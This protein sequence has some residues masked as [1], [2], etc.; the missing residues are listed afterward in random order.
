MSVN[1]QKRARSLPKITLRANDL[2]PQIIQ[3]PCTITKQ[4]MWHLWFLINSPFQFYFQKPK[5][6]LNPVHRGRHALHNPQKYFPPP[7]W[8][9][10]SEV[11]VCVSVLMLLTSRETHIIRVH[12]GTSLTLIKRNPD[13]L[14]PVKTEVGTIGSMTQ[15]RLCWE[16][17]L[18]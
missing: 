2:S 6:T 16:S 18:V 8:R 11:S 3:I 4:N 15:Y 7:K 1:G 14:D 5:S 9:V 17:V 13:F 10:E 12:F